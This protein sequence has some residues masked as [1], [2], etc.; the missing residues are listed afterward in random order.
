MGAQTVLRG[1]R[2][3]RPGSAAGSDPCPAVPN[4]AA[5]VRAVRYPARRAASALPKAVIAEREAEMFTRNRSAARSGPAIE[6]IG[7]ERRIVECADAEVVAS[8]RLELDLARHRPD[9]PE[10]GLGLRILALGRDIRLSRSLASSAW[11]SS[12]RTAWPGRSAA[13][14]RSG[15]GSRRCDCRGRVGRTL[16]WPQI[17]SSSK[18][19]R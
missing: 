13:S 3:R 9:L 19:L 5:V 2:E 14:T 4:P 11:L 10:R 1:R 17:S 16:C 18:F 12:R 8:V 15:G 6:Q 7:R